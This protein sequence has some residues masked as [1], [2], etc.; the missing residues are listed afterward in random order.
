MDPTLV[1]A[2]LVIVPIAF[3]LWQRAN[4]IFCVSVRDGRLLLVRGRIPAAVMHGFADVVKRQN[5]ARGSIRA[6]GGQSHA[7]LSISGM[8]EGTAQRLR[9]VF[10]HHPVQRLRGAKLPEARNVG[11][12]LGIAWLAWLFTKSSS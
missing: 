8:D 9:N 3:L 12:L 5:V 6:I 11:Q 10:G 2:V 1:V 4:E 7:R